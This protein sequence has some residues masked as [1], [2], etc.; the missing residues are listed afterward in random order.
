MTTPHEPHDAI[1][2]DED[3]YCPECF[4]D[5]VIELPNGDLFCKECRA[6]IDY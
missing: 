5:D 4:G 1:A 3:D 2:D 6:I